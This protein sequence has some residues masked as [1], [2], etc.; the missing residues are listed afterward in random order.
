VKYRDILKEIVAHY[1]FE[2]CDDITL[3]AI[4]YNF[5][6]SCPGPYTLEW[7]SGPKSSSYKTVRIKFADLN[8]K[9]LWT[10]KYC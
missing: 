7:Y 2:P 5:Q 9:L 1:I 4:T 8:E 6:L 10:L 3:H